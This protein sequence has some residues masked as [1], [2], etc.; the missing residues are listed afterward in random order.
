M[1]LPSLLPLH[2][3]DHPAILFAG[4]AS[5]WQEALRHAEDPRLLP[6]LEQAEKR[7]SALARE[8]ASVLP[9]GE[10]RLK[11]LLTNP[12]APLLTDED[13]L[14]AISVPG[15]VLAQVAAVLQLQDAGLDVSKPVSSGTPRA[16]SEWRRRRPSHDSRTMHNPKALRTIM[17]L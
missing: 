10:A 14:P 3:F 9:S 6:L 16:A 11:D 17:I 15:I 8:R 7:V 4:Q 2:S 5:P 13:S 1:N 12:D